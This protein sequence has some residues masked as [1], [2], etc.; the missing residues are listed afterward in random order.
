MLE[1][2]DL[3]EATTQGAVTTDVAEMFVDTLNDELNAAI[4]RLHL[5]K[6]DAVEI[7]P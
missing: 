6:I 7:S 5:M 2:A 3:I 4:D 1:E